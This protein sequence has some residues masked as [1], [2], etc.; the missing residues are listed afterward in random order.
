M[1]CQF[2]EINFLPANAANIA[3]LFGTRKVAFLMLNEFFDSRAPEVAE[4]IFEIMLT[5]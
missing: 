1:R 4:E 3:N 5:T 2:S